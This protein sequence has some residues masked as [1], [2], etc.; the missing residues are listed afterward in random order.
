MK[1]ALIGF[2]GIGSIVAEHLGSDPRLRLVGVAARVPQSERVQGILGDVPV[3][4]S[5]AEVLALDPDAVVECAN[6]EA[7]REYAEPVLG[8]GIDL[9]AISVGVLADA[10]YRERLLK[11]AE[12]AKAVLEVPAGA[13][14][15][16]DV[17]AAACRAGLDR[18]AYVTRKS[19]RA[20][21]GTP[22]ESMTDLARVHEPTL[23]FDDSAER[24]ALTFTEKANVTATLA[25]AGVG[26]QRTRVQFWVD[27]AL[28]KSI[29]HIKAEGACGTLKIDLE[30]N[31]AESD[32]RTSLLTAMSVVRAVQNRVAAL[33]I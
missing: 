24:A 23:F 26:F 3:V 8:A 29:H 5:A 10:G 1:L 7:F 30:N 25:L 22:A 13:I 28:D 18:V 11:T 6:H 15:A 16:I 27:P 21:L 9:I 4:H 19:A 33:R 20:W 17:I 2:G 32:G 12:R 31:V 14:G